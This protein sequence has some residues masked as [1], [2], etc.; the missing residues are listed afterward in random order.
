MS[1]VGLLEEK[2]SQVMGP[3]S[4]PSV[5]SLER[6]ED[7]KDQMQA[8]AGARNCLLKEDFWRQDEAWSLQWVVLAP[9][10]CSQGH[11][12]LSDGSAEAASTQRRRL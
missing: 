12:C 11:T 6:H 9:E 8:T 2:S 5:T 7:Q 1:G 4:V 10:H 3:L